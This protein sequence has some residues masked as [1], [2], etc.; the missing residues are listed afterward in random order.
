M[1]LQFLKMHGLG[2]DFIMINGLVQKNIYNNDQELIKMLCDRH[3]GVGADGIIFILKAQQKEADFKM[4]IFNPD[5][6]EAEMCG[7]G[8]RCLAHYLKLNNLTDK[9]KLVIETLAGLIKPEILK[10]NKEQSIVKVNMGHA[11]FSLNKLAINKNLLKSKIDKLSDYPLKIA[12]KK[13]L[14]N[15]VSMGNPHVVIFVD[16]LNNIDLDNVGP[17]IEEHP[18]FL[19]AINVEFVKIVDKNELDVIVWERG[20]GATLACGTG[21]CAVAAVSLDQN[22]ANNDLRLNL[23]GGPL[24]IYKNDHG[25][26]MMTGPS[27]FVYKGEIK[28][29][30]I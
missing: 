12:E 27:T 5:G 2:N 7:N 9:N 14:L 10:Y 13:Y 29:G 21:A 4:R 20:A 19:Q 28:T 3:F 22:R 1:K 15:G 8:I 30:G 26:M 23:P 24:K 17:L 11:H 18:L 25:E 16:D 6:S